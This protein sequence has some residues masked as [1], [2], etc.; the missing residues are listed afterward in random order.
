MFE[1]TPQYHQSLRKLVVA[2]GTMF[3]NI[4]I[5]V[6]GNNI[7]VPLSYS[8]RQRFMAKVRQAQIGNAEIGLTLPRMAFE[9]S[10]IMYDSSR[11]LNSLY[12][13]W[14]SHDT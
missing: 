5:S 1:T 14:I 12:P 8:P 11:K 6:E 10:N 2:F 7:I 3:N 9:L 13:M 4:R